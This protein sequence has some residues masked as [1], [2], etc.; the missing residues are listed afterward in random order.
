MLTLP[1]HLISLPVFSGVHIAQTLVFSVVVYMFAV[2]I[3]VCVVCASVS[4]SIFGC[5]DCVLS[6]WISRLDYR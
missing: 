4:W 2:L 5:L 1:E 6:L 3:V